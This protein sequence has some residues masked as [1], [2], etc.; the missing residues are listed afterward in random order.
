MYKSNLI[1][2]VRNLILLSACFES[3]TAVSLSVLPSAVE[4]VVGIIKEILAL[5]VLVVVVK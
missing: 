4:E 2:S 3:L 5:V 1:R